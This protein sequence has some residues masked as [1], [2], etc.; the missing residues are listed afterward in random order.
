VVD[1]GI[2][3]LKF[4]NVKWRNRTTAGLTH[5]FA[6]YFITVNSRYLKTQ[7]PVNVKAIGLRECKARYLG[8]GMSQQWCH[9]LLYNFLKDA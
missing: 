2:I 3:Q 4:S 1:L 5:F 8:L 6:M 7:L 9:A